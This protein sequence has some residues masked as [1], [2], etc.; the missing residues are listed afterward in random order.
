MGHSQTTINSWRTE[1][2]EINDIIH[3]INK[4]KAQLKDY[5]LADTISRSLL[6]FFYNIG[7]GKM[8]KEELVNAL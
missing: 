7:K 3:Y 4:I 2:S 6:V 8:T 5:S 1:L